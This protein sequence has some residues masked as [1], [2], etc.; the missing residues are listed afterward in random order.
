MGLLDFDDEK[1]LRGRKMRTTGQYN[2]SSRGFEPEPNFADLQKLG[3][4]K[5]SEDFE[6]SPF[7]DRKPKEEEKQV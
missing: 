7:A 4:E 2:F 5:Q 1:I 3:H 6:D